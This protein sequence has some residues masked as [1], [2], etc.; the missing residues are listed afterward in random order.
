MWIFQIEH[1]KFGRDS[2]AVA[3][4]QRF[5]FRSEFDLKLSKSRRSALGLKLQ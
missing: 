1:Q 4:A 2:I 5:A 3:A